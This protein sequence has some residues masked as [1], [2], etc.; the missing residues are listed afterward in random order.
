ML[1][2][3]AKGTADSLSVSVAD[4]PASGLPLINTAN[5]SRVLGT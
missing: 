4:L 1:P 2:A 5:I 3:M